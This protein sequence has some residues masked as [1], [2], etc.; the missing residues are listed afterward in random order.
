MTIHFH[1]AWL[2]VLLLWPAGWWVWARHR[3][4]VQA[5]QVRA[6][7]ARYYREIARIERQEQH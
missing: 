3:A 5:G 2:L 6:V 7:I 1:A 4:R